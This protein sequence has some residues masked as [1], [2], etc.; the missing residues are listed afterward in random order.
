MS[1]NKVGEE[2]VV[3]AVLF[4]LSEVDVCS[5]FLSICTDD[6]IISSVSTDVFVSFG[7]LL[8]DGGGD[9]F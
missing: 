2:N 9:E 1:F 4:C 5:I 8:F 6:S 3:S 7:I